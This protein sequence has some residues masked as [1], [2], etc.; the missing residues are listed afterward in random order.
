[1]ETLICSWW[2]RSSGGRDLW[3]GLNWGPIL[4]KESLS[5]G[6]WCTLQEDSVRLSWIKGCQNWV[7]ACMGGEKSPLL[8]G[9]Q[10]WRV[11]WM[12]NRRNWVWFPPAYPRGLD[13][14][15]L[16]AF[17]PISS[18]VFKQYYQGYPYT[19]FMVGGSLIL[20]SHPMWV[21]HLRVQ[22]KKKWGWGCSSVVECVPYIQGWN[23]STA[24]KEKKNQKNPQNQKYIR[25]CV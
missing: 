8:L 7:L 15:C 21:P 13:Q 6:I 18:L 19:D 25:G 5:C 12:Y 4:V 11:L 14:M 23:P 20:V 24:K 9:L 1:M 16:G 3:L 10:K 22:G 2:I 17:I